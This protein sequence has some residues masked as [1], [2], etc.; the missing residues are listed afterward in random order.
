VTHCLP[1]F[2]IQL[3]LVRNAER[4]GDVKCRAGLRQV[5]NR[6]PERAAV[7][8]DRG[9]LE[10]ATSRSFAIFLHARRSFLDVDRSSFLSSRYEVT[11][12]DCRLITAVILA[13]NDASRIL[14][15]RRHMFASIPLPNHP[16]VPWPVNHISQGK[17]RSNSSPRKI[18][19]KPLEGLVVS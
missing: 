17:V 4:S 3:E 1:A 10:H 6:A 7:E 8:F 18:R 15:H 13:C 5:A 9:A 19:T 16:M 11:L 2:K 14:R 12:I